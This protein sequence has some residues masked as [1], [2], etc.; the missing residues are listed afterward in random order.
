MIFH[1]RAAWGYAICE[2]LHD[3]SG[4]TPA[5]QSRIASTNDAFVT[6]I[7]DPWPGAQE[8]ARFR[9][10]RGAAPPEA[11]MNSVWS[12]CTQPFEVP[13]VT[14]NQPW[15]VPARESTALPMPLRLSVNVDGLEPGEYRASVYVTVPDAFHPR[16]EIP[17]VLEVTD[18]PVAGAARPRWSK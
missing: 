5:V 10:V 2:C 9:H 4:S 11:Q 16:L 1:G 12:G 7:C 17:V 14:A 13:E 15:L 8:P 18:S 3:H 6:Q